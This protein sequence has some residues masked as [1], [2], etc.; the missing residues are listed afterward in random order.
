MYIILTSGDVLN[1]RLK[2]AQKRRTMWEELHQTCEVAVWPFTCS[3]AKVIVIT[4]C[5]NMCLM[6]V[7]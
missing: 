6:S 3:L 2:G 4:N 5:L 1:H 7:E